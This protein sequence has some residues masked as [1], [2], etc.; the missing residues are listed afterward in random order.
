MRHLSKQAVAVG[1]GAFLLALVWWLPAVAYAG[2]ADCALQPGV[3]IE[4]GAIKKY[5]ALGNV[6]KIVKLGSIKYLKVR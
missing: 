4:Q 2:P 3:C 1:L 6:K 5:V